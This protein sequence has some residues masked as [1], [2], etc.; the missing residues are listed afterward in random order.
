NGNACSTARRAA[1]AQDVNPCHFS[2]KA[3]KYVGFGTLCYLITRHVGHRVAKCTG[4]PLNTRGRHHYLTKLLNV[5][6]HLH[7]NNRSL[8]Y[9]NLK[10]CEADKREYEGSPLRMRDAI[11][12]VDIRYGSDGRTFDDDIH[13]GQ[14]CPIFRGG[15]PSRNGSLLR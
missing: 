15:D 4:L 7:I 2:L 13:A 11:V 6:R 1:R 8:S 10:G 12:S 5:L 14:R 3:A 9:R